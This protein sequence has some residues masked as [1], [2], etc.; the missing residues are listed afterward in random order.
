M[1]T[2]A[3]ILEK[4][5]DED[6]QFV[7]LQFTDMFGT[8]KNIAVTANHLET[9]L[10]NKF[11]IDGSVLFGEYLECEEDLYLFPVLESFKIL[12]WRPQQGRV[13]KFTCAICYEDGTLYEMSSRSILNNVIEKAK[14]L[15]YRFLIHPE[16]EFFLF[17]CDDNNLPTTIT[18]EQAGFMDVGP[19]DLGENARRDMVLNLEEMGFEIESSHHEKAPAQHEIDFKEASTMKAADSLMTFK[20]A[21]RSIAKRFGLYATFMP[22]P[23]A[24]CPGSGMHLNI[25]IL[26]DEKNISDSDSKET[27]NDASKYFIAGILK[28]AKGMCIYTNPLV[29]SYKRL[30]SG[31]EAPGTVSWGKKGER[32]LVRLRQ[33]KEDS[34]IEL[35]LPDPS[36]NP[37]LALA[38]CIAAGMDGIE[39]KLELA[40]EFEEVAALPSD[41]KEAI[42]CS[43]EDAFIRGI[44]GEEFASIYEQAKMDE[45]NSYSR[46]VSEWEINQ[47][48][49]KM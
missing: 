15:G 39:N 48:L 33:E 14:S 45:W 36:A 30:G 8:L 10:S 4:I 20:F 41:L 49:Y 44:M 18:H 47:Y 46:T 3:E 32:T 22:K 9:I 38:A 26:K 21:V 29:N 23:K 11:R 28:H 1:K 12:A 25:S 43:K 19:V 35:R 6:V 31:F 17:H 34:K 7:R 42:A 40:N 13:A 27:V 24:E 2:V 37:Y 16:C 5:E